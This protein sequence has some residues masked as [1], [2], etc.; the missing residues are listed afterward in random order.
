MNENDL[1]VWAVGLYCFFTTTAS[2]D[3]DSKKKKMGKG[4]P[5]VPGASKKK[6]SKEESSGVPDSKRK[7]LQARQASHASGFGGGVGQ[8][9]SREGSEGA[10]DSKRKPVDEEKVWQKTFWGDKFRVETS[11]PD[12]KGHA[13]SMYTVWKK[14]VAEERMAKEGRLDRKDKKR[15]WNY[16]APVMRVRMANV[17][18][19]KWLLGDEKIYSE[20]CEPFNCKYSLILA[21]ENL[22]EGM[23][24]RFEGDSWA[25]TF[26][27]VGKQ[28]TQQLI[29]FDD[30]LIDA[31]WR[32][33]VALKQD[34]TRVDDDRK[35]CPIDLD[36]E[37]EFRRFANKIRGTHGGVR[38][39]KET[40]E[41]E[42]HLKT[43]AYRKMKVADWAR[44]LELTKKQLTEYK[45]CSDDKTK[46]H[47][48]KKASLKKHGQISPDYETMQDDTMRDL[49]CFC[50]GYERVLIKLQEQVD[51]SRNRWETIPDCKE[52]QQ[53]KSLIS[54]GDYVMPNFNGE[55]YCTGVA[56][57]SR[58]YFNEL[59][60]VAKGTREKN[61]A[62]PS[63]IGAT[64]RF[65]DDDDEEEDPMEE[66][67]PSFQAPYQSSDDEGEASADEDADMDADDDSE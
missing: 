62:P 35:V 45:T 21:L 50:Q 10:P 25:Q 15:Y 58:Y 16:T 34:K 53:S 22:D 19:G 20:K 24:E 38:H 12:G 60:F 67:T 28:F 8:K 39:N 52:K 9:R 7:N 56:T 11:A 13:L 36:D 17:G 57:G 30:K 32:D 18:G 46:T 4:P 14:S 64:R 47:F 61:T 43:N 26:A 3:D 29:S 33:P 23:E 54:G 37:K 42:W 65:I 2:T 5:P 66:E 44:Q 27:S 1:W 59:F 51:P 6:H 48:L 31:L 40:G 63:D 49:Y 41:L 55:P